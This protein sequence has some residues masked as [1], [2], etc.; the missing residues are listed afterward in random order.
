MEYYDDADNMTLNWLLLFLLI[1][2]DTYVTFSIIILPLL[3]ERPELRL[4][5]GKCLQL[6]HT[7][8]V[9]LGRGSLFRK[10]KIKRE[11]MLLRDNY[12]SLL[13]L[14]MSARYYENEKTPISRIK[15]IT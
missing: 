2:K 11:L 14:A 10:K 15:K 8:I 6:R 5:R 7:K 12:I 4:L 3:N 1:G 9:R 13:R